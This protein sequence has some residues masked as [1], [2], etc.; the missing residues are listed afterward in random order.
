M[1]EYAY[2]RADLEAMLET[3]RLDYKMIAIVYRSKSSDPKDPISTFLEQHSLEL[4]NDVKF[5]VVNTDN[6][7]TDDKKHYDIENATLPVIVF[8]YRTKNV[9]RISGADYQTLLFEYIK[10]KKISNDKKTRDTELR[11]L[12]EAR[13]RNGTYT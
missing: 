6:L 10:S 4:V 3:L 12:E 13:I 1:V 2:R 5:V 11:K 7:T 8:R 9:H